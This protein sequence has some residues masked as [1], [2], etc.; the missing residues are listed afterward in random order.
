MSGARLDLD[1]P[2]RAL[3]ELE[4]PELDPDRAFEWSPGL[5]AARATVLE[6]LGR[7]AEAE[8][9][10]RRAEVA[11]EALDAASGVGDLETIF[12]EEVEELHLHEDDESHAEGDIGDSE[13]SPADESGPAAPTLEVATANDDDDDDEDEDEVETSFSEEA[14]PTEEEPEEPVNIDA[15]TVD[16]AHLERV[17]HHDAEAEADEPAPQGN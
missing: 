14:A 12:I 1:Q 3:L 10:H 15:D 8:E 13:P 7:D 11:A 5:F 16:D 17:T 2:D 6:E 9:W 4:I